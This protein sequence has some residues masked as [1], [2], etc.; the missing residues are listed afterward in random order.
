[1]RVLA[2]CDYYSPTSCGGSER[3]AR[4]V[5]TRLVRD[6]GVNVTLV[7][8]VPAGD[9]SATPRL[10]E[11]DAE[12]ATV[13]VPAHDLSAQLG[14]QLLL[15]GRLPAA[16]NRLLRRVRPDVLHANS[17]HFQS[18]FVAAA[19]AQ[20]YRLPL[21]TTAHLGG[22][23]ALR[24]S[25]RAAAAGW[26]HTLGRMAVAASSGLVAVSESVA[27]HLRRLGAGRRPLTVA[28]N[29]V[30]HARFHPGSRV[31]A[32]G[33][34]RL[35]YVGRLITNKGPDLLLD[36]TA[37]AVAAGTDLRLTFIG[38]GPMRNHLQRD[39]DRAGLRHLVTFTGQVDDVADR[40]RELDVVARPSYTEGLPLAV[41]EAMASGAVVVCTAIPG[42]LELVQHGVTGLV[43]PI[44][45]AA[46]LASALTR[47]AEDHGLLRQL[48]VNALAHAARYSWDTS[49]A[50]H[51]DALQQA[52]A[53]ERI[54]A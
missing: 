49:A 52:A 16:A 54:S 46:A 9:L 11:A 53:T 45:A 43:V 32:D 6:H 8:S 28:P 14:V 26:D 7:G 41:I 47:L 19:L 34:L 12:M 18:T 13:L 29:G 17:L 50:L 20:R 24:G 3:V 5:Y 2:F 1:M 23:D 36:A 10:D 25:L 37:R 35:G 30:D 39:V 31:D 38:D 15:S 51:L 48:R 27:A 22:S 42:N 33:P 4:E 40:L 21:V 44:G